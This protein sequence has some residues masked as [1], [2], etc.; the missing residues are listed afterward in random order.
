MALLQTV[1]LTPDGFGAV[2]ECGAHVHVS[3]VFED[4]AGG[5]VAMGRVPPGTAVPVSHQEIA[6]TCDSCG[7]SHWVRVTPTKDWLAGL[8]ESD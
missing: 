2:C 7:R 5:E 6:F 4:G 8:A 1:W 3:I